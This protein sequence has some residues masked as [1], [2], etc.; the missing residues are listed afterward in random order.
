MVVAVFHVIL[1]FG[2]AGTFGYFYEQFLVAFFEGGHL[3][4]TVCIVNIFSLILC[5]LAK[6]FY[7]AFGDCFVIAPTGENGGCC[8]GDKNCGN[9]GL[10]LRISVFG[11]VF[12]T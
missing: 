8:Q 10:L 5:L 2:F 9:L 4:A 6:F 12:F 1:I 3:L 7:V 11:Y